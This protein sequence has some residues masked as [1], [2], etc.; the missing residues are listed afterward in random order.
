M[1]YFGDCPRNSGTKSS[2]RHKLYFGDYLLKSETNGHLT[3]QGRIILKW[4]FVEI[5]L[6]GEDWIQ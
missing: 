3:I 5:G 2:R 6:E 4:I 1:S